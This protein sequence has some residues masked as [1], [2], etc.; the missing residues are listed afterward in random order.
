MTFYTLDLRLEP[1]MQHKLIIPVDD[2]VDYAVVA[3]HG[4]LQLDDR[5]GYPQAVFLN[6]SGVFQLFSFRG[7]NT[8]M[9]HHWPPLTT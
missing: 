9:Q 1:I 6:P 3:F 5:C 4:I 8:K 7:Q 2:A